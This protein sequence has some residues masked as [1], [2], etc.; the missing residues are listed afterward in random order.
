MRR[1]SVVEWGIRHGAARVLLWAVVPSLTACASGSPEPPD[2]AVG[3]E[4]RGYGLLVMAH[5]GSPEWNAA[6]REAVAPVRNELPTALAFGM[7]D[8]ESLRAAAS[9]LESQGV[10]RIAVVRLFISG[11]SFYERTLEALSPL[12]PDF[13]ISRAGLIESPLAGE[14]MR[15]RVASLSRDPSGESVLILAHGMGEE[16]ENDRLLGH[17]EEVARAVREIGPF[18]EVRTETL[19]EDWPEKR[20]PSERGIRRWVE[21][22]S[23]TGRV[24]VV[25]LRLYGFGPYESVLEGLP[26]VADGTGFVPH[27]L[28]TSWIRDATAEAFCRAGWEATVVA[29][30]ESRPLTPPSRTTPARSGTSGAMGRRAR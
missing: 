20:E 22:R 15:E 29:C 17:M 12:S 7:A 25:P 4:S 14:I 24:I 6:V 27:P 1:R 16:S 28:I 19:R 11:S 18:R 8:P 13:A 30:A 10:S 23:R 9:R 2:R 3:V 26:Y 5:G 21:A